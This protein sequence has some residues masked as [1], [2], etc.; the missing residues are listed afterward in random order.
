VFYP[1][2]LRFRG[3]AIKAGALRTH[4]PGPS[5][6]I[7]LE[8]FMGASERKVCCKYERITRGTQEV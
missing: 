3:K 5:E 6:T 7:R 2:V 8:H 4:K 1:S